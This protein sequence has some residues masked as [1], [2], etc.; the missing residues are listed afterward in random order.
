MP[1]VP[2][3]WTV[4]DENDTAQIQVDADNI[5]EELGDV[6]PADRKANALMALAQAIRI[7]AI[8][9]ATRHS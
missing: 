8:G 5:I 3:L 4:D 2:N 6:D 7:K 9:M 1:P